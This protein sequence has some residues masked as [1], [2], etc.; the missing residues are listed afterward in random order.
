MYNKEKITEDGKRMLELVRNYR[1]EVD[2]GRKMS[3]RE[4]SDLRVKLEQLASVDLSIHFAFVLADKLKAIETVLTSLD[5][6]E[7]NGK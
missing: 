3:A 4:L 1:H 6:R 2:N 7:R 5:E